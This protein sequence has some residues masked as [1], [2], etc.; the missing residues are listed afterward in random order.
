MKKRIIIIISAL[1]LA[2]L[3]TVICY[4]QLA[5]NERK[6]S[7]TEPIVTA[8]PETTQQK[9]TEIGKT[10]LAEFKPFECS[11]DYYCFDREHLKDKYGNELSLSYDAETQIYEM[12]IC[13]IE[14]YSQKSENNSDIQVYSIIDNSLFFLY[15]EDLYRI[16]LSYDNEKVI[17]GELCLVIKYNYMHPLKAYDNTLILTGN[18]YYFELDT[19]SGFHETADFNKTID[20]AAV[21]P[22]IA[23]NTACSL[24]RDAVNDI[25]NYT[26]Y[27]EEP[28]NSNDFR[29]MTDEVQ[30]I[31]NPD[32]Y[33]EEVIH[34]RYPQYVWR[35]T[36]TSGYDGSNGFTINAYINADSGEVSAMTVNDIGC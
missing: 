23:F 35:V 8:E 17:K 9:T 2:L 3:I 19:L 14:I 24:A 13:D 18:S 16:E 30:L 36:L 25:N 29:V 26:Q 20:S 7:Y 34:E 27:Y 15:D 32:L 22:D 28:Y 5:K 4:S 31:K 10:Y 1:F 33:Y 12:R 21:K 6:T 11:G